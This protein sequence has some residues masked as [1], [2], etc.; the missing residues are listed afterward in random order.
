MAKI[1]LDCDPGLDDALA[2]VLAHGDPSIELVAVTTVG[3]NVALRNTTRNALQL[4]EYLGFESVPIAAG[5]AVPLVR[6]V[7]DA[8]HVHGEEGMG[9]VRLPEPA[10][11]ASAL[12]AVDLIIET[13]RAA[14]G[15]IH[16]VATGPLTNI[17]LAVQK[18]PNIVSWAASFV[19]MGGSFTRGNTTAAAEFNIYADAEAAAIVFAAGWQV[20]MVGLDL[21]LQAIATPPIVERMRSLGTL[22]EELLAPL[23]TFWVN[24][25]DANWSGQ[26][27]HDVCAVAYVVRPDLFESR[28]A[29]VEIETQG[30]FTYGMTVVDFDSPTPNALVPVRIDVD[31]F[32]DYVHTQWATITVGGTK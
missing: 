29:R 17:A 26:A 7:E 18:E 21:T 3:G 5:A 30:Q 8:A 6:E 20:V 23:A 10:L 19:I 24:P 4:R 25:A 16:L 28:P 32:W 2:L 27:V 1:L 22:G 14:P 9:T 31:G 13:L 11:E 15:T 12:H